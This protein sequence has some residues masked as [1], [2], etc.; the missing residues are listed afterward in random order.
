M[1][2]EFQSYQNKSE[3]NNV[4]A[5]LSQKKFGV[6]NNGK[7]TERS[8]YEVKSKISDDILLETKEF[9]ESQYQLKQ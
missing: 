9:F 8:F 4:E 7:R 6:W 1:T 5:K 2:T 3:E